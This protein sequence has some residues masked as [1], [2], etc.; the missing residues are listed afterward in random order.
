MPEQW[1]GDR[2]PLGHGRL[3]VANAVLLVLAWGAIVLGGA[4]SNVQGALELAAYG[5]IILF[6][7][8]I[9]VQL[10]IVTWFEGRGR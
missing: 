8:A 3:V 7:V 2:A 4:R 9:L 5:T 1:G 6:V 10:L